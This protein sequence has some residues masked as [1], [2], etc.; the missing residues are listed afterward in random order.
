MLTDGFSLF[1]VSRMS[2]GINPIKMLFAKQGGRSLREF[3]KEV[4]VSPAYLSDLYA[5]KRAPG[6]V[7]LKYLRLRRTIRKIVKYDKL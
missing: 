1:T 6:K 7:I 3:S 4:G 5:G 2:Q